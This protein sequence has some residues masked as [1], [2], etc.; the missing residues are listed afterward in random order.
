[1]IFRSVTKL[2]FV[3]MLLAPAIMPVCSWG[4]PAEVRLS[5]GQTVYVPVYSNVYS[6]PRK[7]PFQLAALLSI[8]NTDMTGT[9]RVTAI[10]YYDN[11]GRLIK[12]H[13]DRPLLLGPLGTTHVYVEEK[14]SRG[15]FGANFIVRWSADRVI[16]APVIECVMIGATGGQGISFVSPGQEIRE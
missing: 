8:R 14:D 9:F 13:L 4:S 3:V 5:K 10:D 6:G 2:I 15:G 7:N 11:D 1:M 16:N 12:R